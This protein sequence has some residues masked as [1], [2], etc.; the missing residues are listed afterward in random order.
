MTEQR[1]P[2]GPAFEMSCR[3]HGGHPATRPWIQLT[4]RRAWNAGKSTAEECA[5]AF[6]GTAHLAAPMN[7]FVH[8]REPRPV[9]QLTTARVRS[10]R[11]DGR[12]EGWY[13]RR[14]R[15]IGDAVRRWS[16]ARR[17]AGRRRFDG[18]PR[19]L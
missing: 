17:R 9:S 5:V 15:L 12:P 10:P 4:V 8:P 13:G 3:C 16:R 7:T 11:T 1:A 19:S 6:V 2:G 14:T 18:R